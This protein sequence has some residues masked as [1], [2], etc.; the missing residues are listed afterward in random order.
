MKKKVIAVTAARSEYDLMS[1]VFSLLNN[2]ANFEFSLIVAGPHLSSTF[3]LSVDEIKKD[4]FH[5]CDYCFNL[6]DSDEKIARAMAIGNQIPL[7]AQTFYRE[8][9]D[10]VIVAGDREDVLSV[11]ITAAYMAIPVAHFFGGDIAKDGN[12]DNAARYASSK[13]ANIHFVTLPEHKQ[14]LL[15]LGEDEWRVHVVGNPGLDRFKSVKP[16]GR[17]ELFDRL[18]MPELDKYGLVIKHS[19]ISEVNS[20][21]IDMLITMEALLESGLKWFINSPNS[22]SGSAGIRKVITKYC[23][24]YPDKFFSFKNLDRTSYVNLLR[25]A[26]VLVGNS[27]S[28]LLEAPSLGLPVVNIGQRQRGRTHGD[29]VLFVDNKKDDILSAIER[30]LNDQT[31]LNSVKKCENP[32]GSGNSSELILEI[33]ENLDITEDLIFKNITY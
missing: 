33:L 29:N 16:L 6:V 15:K 18:N 9:P 32:Y 26:S 10:I 5:I 1:S 24:A 12:I 17:I 27:S 2:N 23:V 3:G 13:F 7:L 25:N 21:E 30:C 20:Q 31:F 22:D 28:G 14:T 11:C 19:I 4:G 8:Q